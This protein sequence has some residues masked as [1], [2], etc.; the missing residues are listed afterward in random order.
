MG[1]RNKPHDRKKG[2]GK[3]A[4]PY[5]VMAVLDSCDIVIPSILI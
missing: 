1:I 2:Y 4:K 3:S 5:L